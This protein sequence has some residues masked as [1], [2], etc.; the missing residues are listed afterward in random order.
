MGLGGLKADTVWKSLAPR[1]DGALGV[2]PGDIERTGGG[3][4]ERGVAEGSQEG[5]TG[6]ARVLDFDSLLNVS[7]YFMVC[8]ALDMFPPFTIFIASISLSIKAYFKRCDGH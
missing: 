2:E 3:V 4:C 5:E 6:Q 8:V 1:L 7:V